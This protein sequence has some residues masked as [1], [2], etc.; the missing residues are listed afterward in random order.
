ML[1]DEALEVVVGDEGCVLAVVERLIK[2]YNAYN[3]KLGK[4]I[5]ENVA[6]EIIV[7]NKKILRRLKDLKKQVEHNL[8]FYSGV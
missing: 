5:D 4:V 2:L 7:G 6:N 3:K 8:S 1:L